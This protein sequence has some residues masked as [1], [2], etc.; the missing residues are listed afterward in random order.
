MPGL[1]IHLL[2]TP[3]KCMVSLY[4]SVCLGDSSAP[5]D[6][7]AVGI[8]ERR[9]FPQ[10]DT[11]QHFQH[12]FRHLLPPGEDDIYIPLSY[13]TRNLINEA[14]LPLNYCEES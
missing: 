10:L 1:K 5:E 2:E 8:C 11:A 14:H 12:H 3:I 7:E 4:V 9:L 13:K 6:K